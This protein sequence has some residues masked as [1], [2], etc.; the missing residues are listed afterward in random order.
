ME[1]VLFSRVAQ[2]VISLIYLI[3]ISDIQ[4]NVKD[5]TSLIESTIQTILS[6]CTGCQLSKILTTAIGKLLLLIKL[7]FK[8]LNTCDSSGTF[9]L[10]ITSNLR[11][12]YLLESQFI[13]ILMKTD[14]QS[15]ERVASQNVYKALFN[16]LV[17][18]WRGVSAEEQ[19]IQHRTA[20]AQEYVLFLGCDILKIDESVVVSS[21]DEATLRAITHCLFV[22]QDILE[23]YED[24]NSFTKSILTNALRPVI[25]KAVFLFHHQNPKVIEHILNFFNSLIK[26]LQ[27]QLGASA[28]KELLLLFIE[29]CKKEQLEQAQLR[30]IDKLLHI[31]LVIIKQHG[32]SSAALIPDIL[33]LTLEQV[34]PLVFTLNSNY[35]ENI[36]V[37]MSLYALFDGILQNRWQY[38]YKSQV[39]RGFSPGAGDEASAA[40]S[41]ITPAHS[42]QFSSILTAY[43]HALTAFN[44]PEMMRAVLESLQSIDEKYKLFHSHFFIVNFSTAFQCAI[45]RCLAAP[46]GSLNFD[47][48]LGVL[49]KMSQQG[50]VLE[51]VLRE[52]D[53][54]M[55][56]KTIEA[57]CTATVSCPRC[58]SLII[59]KISYFPFDRTFPHLHLTYPTWYRI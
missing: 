56:R 2:L 18:Q 38:F 24:S 7:R 49:F 37:I 33:N 41:D 14:L 12:K 16:C 17:L 10:N 5:M 45:L 47:L 39:L 36:D 51:R 32:N 55:N 35:T 48:L 20:I 28:I 22:F 6:S 59:I 26:T 25:E 50:Q 43:G 52:L 29:S 53:A 21:L 23:Y 42:E 34:A 11:P 15:L 3:P 31:F 4:N 57:I 30:W 8:E 13:P 27:T 9:L 58:H 54:S 46:E 44:H 40:A 1:L 19:N